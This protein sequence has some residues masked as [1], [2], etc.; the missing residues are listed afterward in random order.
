MQLGPTLRG[1]TVRP[2]KQR[3]I[4]SEIV[5][6]RARLKGHHRAHVALSLDLLY[7]EFTSLQ[8]GM[9]NRIRYY[10]IAA[11][12]HM[13]SFFKTLV[14]D[15]IDAGAP[16]LENAAA[17]VRDTKFDLALLQA[18]RHQQFSVGELVG[19]ILAFSSYEAIERAM[20]ELTGRDFKSGLS[21]RMSKK[22]GKSSDIELMVKGVV[23]TF[24]LRHMYCHEAPHGE[25]P[26]DD[27][28]EAC[29]GHCIDFLEAADTW[30]SSILEPGAP[31]AQGEMS[32]MAY[33]KF[34]E[35]DAEMA[36]TLKAASI[37]RDGDF[38]KL[39]QE[40]QARWLKYR[41]AEGELHLNRFAGGTIAPMVRSM[42]LEEL[43]RWR[44]KEL[45]RLV[46]IMSPA[47]EGQLI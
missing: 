3:D 34:Q 43:T 35:A 8:R 22:N 33:K 18:I 2:R 24:R 26:T 9:G 13:E 10:P 20:T 29:L 5:E 7:D 16:Y 25:N 21:G 42:K 44:Q 14:A 11:V 19:H 12:A 45:A 4:A 40:A 17:V 30:A 37:N 23:E 6:R 47:G 27:A 38:Q 1:V 41:D 39:L 28:V 31:Y 46:E 15:F 32:Q 36:A